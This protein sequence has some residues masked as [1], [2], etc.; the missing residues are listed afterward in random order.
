MLRN[1]VVI[2]IQDLK[3]KIKYFLRIIHHVLIDNIPD[4]L[5]NNRN[6]MIESNYMTKVKIENISKLM[7]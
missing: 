4:A 7:T 3:T 6:S 5:L 2:M 1:F